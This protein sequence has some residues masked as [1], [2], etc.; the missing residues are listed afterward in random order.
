MPTQHVMAETLVQRDVTAPALPGR[1]LVLVQGLWAMLVVLVLGLFVVAVPA[2]YSQSLVPDD[3]VAAGLAQ[4]GLSHRLYATYWVTIHIVFAL[5]YFVVAALIAWRKRDDLLALFVSLFLV[6]VGG[7][8]AATTGALLASYPNLSLLVNFLF[9]LTVVSLILFFFLFPDGRFAPGTLRLPVLVWALAVLFIFLLSELSPA[10]DPPL[11]VGL[12]VIAGLVAGGAAQIYRY[13]RVSTPA[14]RQQTKWVVFGATGAVV[15]QIAAIFLEDLFP[16]ATAPGPAALLYDL[17][18][19]TIIVFSFLL[20]PLSIGVAILQRRLWDIDIIINRTLLYAA[21]SAS[22]VG[23]YVLIVGGL[24]TMFQTQGNLAI[25]LFATGIVAILFQSLRERLQGAV[26]RLMFGER[27]DPY[28]VLARLDQRLE[29]TIASGAVLPT[30]VSTVGDALKLPYVAITLRQE[31]RFS[32]TAQHGRPTDPLLRLPLVY[33]SEVVGELLLASRGRGELFNAADRRLLEDVARHAGV[34]AHGVLLTAELQRSRERLVTTRE[35]E[36]RRIRRDLH[37][38]LGPQ[39][40]S[41]TLTIAAARQLLAYDPKA[42]DALLQ[43]LSAHAQAAITDIRRVIYG[44]RP[45]ALDDLGLISALQEQVVHAGKQGLH[46]VIDGPERLPAMPAAVEV[47][48]YR[49]VTE[50]LTNVM[51]HAAADTCIVRLVL[52]HD[53]V[54]EVRDDGCGLPPG[55]RAGV[56]LSSMRERAEELGGTCQIESVPGEGTRVRARLPVRQEALCSGS[57]S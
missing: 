37:D 10:P 35:E 49:I 20:I 27:D 34:A 38:G 41:L 13:L 56:G 26:N 12:I 24:G 47:A 32:V 17:A 19:V 42:T 57:E 8:N 21:L 36:R 4:L 18:S 9:V 31:G 7:A 3:A 23:L 43:E 22:I 48:A 53:L 6:L 39:L 5:V 51:R 50:A 30:I 40:A 33:Q 2:L 25:S 45:P 46:V 1:W 52:E 16:S 14:Q 15:G 11:L 29:A 28:A 55:G 54:L 44:L